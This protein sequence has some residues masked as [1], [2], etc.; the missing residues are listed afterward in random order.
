MVGGKRS[1]TRRNLC[2]LKVADMVCAPNV[3]T[4][5]N[6]VLLVQHS[7]LTPLSNFEITFESISL[8]VLSA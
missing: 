3:L 2:Q 8:L 5:Y 6:Q 1:C 4:L 7:N